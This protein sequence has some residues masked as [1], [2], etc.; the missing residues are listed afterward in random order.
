MAKSGAAAKP[1]HTLAKSYGV[2]A[3][4]WDMN[5]KLQT[6]SD[7]ALMAV[8]RI[9]GTSLNRPSD[10]RAA[11]REREQA[12]WRQVLEPVSVVWGDDNAN[13][14]LRLP[15]GSADA[16][17]SGTL[18]LE[19]GQ[20]VS[21]NWRG[22]DLPTFDW[23]EV[24]RESYVLKRLAIPGPLPTGYHRLAIQAVGGRHESL[25][26]AAPPRACVAEGCRGWGVF[27]PLYALHRDRGWGC[28][29]Y[30]DLEALMRW[31]GSLGGTSVSTLPLLAS[32]LDNPYEPSPY[33]PVSRLFWNEFYVDI[34]S[35][36][37]LPFCPEA[38]VLL[39]SASTKSELTALR[40]GSCVDFR[41]QMA[42]KRHILEDLCRCCLS[43]ESGRLEDLK[44]FS[45]SNRWV[46]DYAAFRA[47][48]EK[49]GVTWSEWPE[50][51]RNGDVQPGDFDA[52]SRDYHLYV[53]WLATQQLQSLRRVGGEAG[54]GLYLDLPLGTNPGGYDVWR[55]RD[56]FALGASG[57]AP[58]DSFF[59]KGQDWG[60]PPLH[61]ESIR[62]NGYS[63]F[64]DCLRHLL[65]CA[66][67]LRID[68][69]M[70][71]HRLFWVPQGMGP[72]EGVYVNYHAD[73]FYAILA[74]ESQRHGALIVGEDLGTVPDTVR[75][76]MDKRGLQRM[77][78]V[79]YEAQPDATP[80]LREV[81]E[82]MVANLNTHDMP[83]FAAFWR[84]LDVVDR[85][86]LGLLD[87]DGVER[88]RLRRRAMKQALA[89][90]FEVGGSREAL[91][92]VLAAA[93]CF[94]GASQ[95]R[96]VLVNL[97]DLWLE[98]QPQNTP[99]TTTE[100]QNWCRKARYSLDQFLEM[101]GVIEPLGALDRAR[102]ARLTPPVP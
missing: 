14:G 29:S 97:E 42:L 6:A 48:T 26:I 19:D 65:S 21:L 41:R 83:T 90:Y 76:T 96:I 75:S 98:T 7:E 16:T 53:Q 22:S 69:V 56:A 52:A 66:N 2:E 77:Y 101:P 49:Q 78:V 73:E 86:L 11:I 71:F 18:R 62:H 55:H 31:V 15:A 93:L 17:I 5:G 61:P 102:K 1:L 79:Q 25:L 37:E 87:E 46:N 84:E 10:A 34:E 99:G 30:A 91:P 3:G 67:V 9:L 58:P 28:G 24:G 94:L 89:D 4:Y 40:R 13:L 20:E 44:R 38:Q 57:G 82:D 92:R 50:R 51:L 33:S 59:I 45:A 60:F 47:T 85:Q 68:H 54:V 12:L 32:F 80:P 23:G 63:Y 88:E 39:A 64:I 35:V 95:A 81:P 36:P 43:G 8:L 70:Q 72:K 74:L 27:L 100:R